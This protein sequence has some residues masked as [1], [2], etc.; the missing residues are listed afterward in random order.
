M[1]FRDGFSK[2]GMCLSLECPNGL[3]QAAVF[4]CLENS[5]DF[6]IYLSRKRLMA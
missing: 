6:N 4:N 3:N 5:A 2:S 1:I